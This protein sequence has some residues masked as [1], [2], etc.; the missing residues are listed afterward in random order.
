[1]IRGDRFREI[2]YGPIVL[3]FEKADISNRRFQGLKETKY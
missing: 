2:R 1:M 3:I